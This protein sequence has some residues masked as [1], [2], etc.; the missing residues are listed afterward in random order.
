MRLASRVTTSEFFECQDPARRSDQVPTLSEFRD[1]STDFLLRRVERARAKGHPESAGAEWSACVNRSARR[2]RTVVNAFRT[3]HGDRIPI[4]DRDIVVNRALDR[5]HRRILH[6]LEK[7]NE[8]SFFAA[9][10]SV[11]DYTC[12]DHIRAIGAYRRGL[13]GS[14]DEPAYENGGGGR[15]D[16]ELYREALKREI[17][18]EAAFDAADRVER[19]LAAMKNAKRR[20][21]VDMRRLGCEYE[22]IAAA[23]GV[24]VDNAYQLVCRGF[25]DLRGS[26]E[27]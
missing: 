21:A 20:R 4:G 10:A 22:E 26:I 19:G 13:H 14:L 18:D 16:D 5:G 8:V 12:K 6:N 1:V 17:D 23:L 25:R 9:M 24:S 2:V 3:A 15:Y 27:T 7:F 11:A